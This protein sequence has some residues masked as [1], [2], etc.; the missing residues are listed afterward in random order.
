MNAPNLAICV[1]P[2]ILASST[3]ST[4]AGTME[5]MGRAQSLL[6]DMIIQCEWIFEDEETE[7]QI[8]EKCVES[9]EQSGEN[10]KEDQVSGAGPPNEVSTEIPSVM[11]V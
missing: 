9:A 11:S 2:V 1:A 6:R 7:E 8:A 4:L 10:S 3:S 5:S